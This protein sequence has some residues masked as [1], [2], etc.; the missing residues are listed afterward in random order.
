MNKLHKPNLTKARKRTKTNVET[1]EYKKP[2]IIN[3]GKG[4]KYLIQTHGCQ[5]NEADTEVMQGL[6][7]EQGFTK[8]NV[9]EETDLLIIN[10]CAIR[11]NA[12]NKVFGELGRLK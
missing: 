8:T 12:E 5:A 6:L 4:K 9:I 11:E 10:T 2:D 1:K 7:E 3:L